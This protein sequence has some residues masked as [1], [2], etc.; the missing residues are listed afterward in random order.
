[1]TKSLTAFLA[2]VM[3]PLFPLFALPPQVTNISYHQ[4]AGVDGNLTKLVDIH[5]DLE[6]NRSMYVEFFFSP[7][8][9]DSFP[10]HCTAMVGASGMGVTA[11]IDLNATWDASID[12]DQNFT[13][14]GRIMVKATYGSQPTGVPGMEGN[15]TGT[16]DFMPNHF[17]PSAMNLEM[18]WVD[19]GTFTMGSPTSEPDRGTDETEHM[20]TLS[21]GFYLGK[22]EVTQ[23][24]Y[25][26]VMA[27]NTDGINATPS[28]WTGSPNLPV[29]YVSWNKIQ[30]FL[31][32]LNN[33]EQAAG[34]L[35]GGWEYV[36]PTEAEWEYACRAGTTTAYSWGA[37]INAS[38]ANSV[39]SGFQQTVAVGSF[40]PNPWGFHD[41]HGNVSELVWDLYDGA[42]PTQ[43]V[44]DPSNSDFGT[45]RV[46]R[47]GS[48][49]LPATNIRSSI[50]SSM[51]PY[52]SSFSTGFRLAY[53]QVQ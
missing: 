20:V 12:W 43:P 40:P 27:G 30:T 16:N 53:K 10:V 45:W 3:T 17:V 19:P 4:R 37:D 8:G 32:R 42:Y 47:G 34:G 22:Y 51:E 50:R 18:I 15:E 25:E 49:D 39:E 41:M 48:W 29:E 11:G 36:L 6:G 38:K 9:G 21:S 26:A 52:L 13:D 14:R 2:C 23:E 44:T 33:S 7:D 5:Y 35:P 28:Q 1:M 24:Q 46:Y 31:N